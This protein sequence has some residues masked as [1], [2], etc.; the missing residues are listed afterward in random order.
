MPR[1]IRFLLSQFFNGIVLGLAVAEVVLFTDFGQLSR[2]ISASGQSG[3]L[4]AL[5][6]VQSG[7]LF[8]TLNMAVAV[9]TLPARDR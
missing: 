6:F 5:F 1:L 4:T 3:P 9:L 7:L 2:L 8:G